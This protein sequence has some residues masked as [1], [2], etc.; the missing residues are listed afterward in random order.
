MTLFGSTSKGEPMRIKTRVGD[1]MHA[2]TEVQG[3]LYSLAQSGQWR[4]LL[5]CL[6]NGEDSKETAVCRGG[7]WR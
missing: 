4:E 6:L 2:Q 1:A 7:G 3:R 5:L